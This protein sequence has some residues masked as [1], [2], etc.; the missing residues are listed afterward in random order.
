MPAIISYPSMLPQGQTRDQIVTIMDWFPTVLD[1]CGAKQE[2]SA[3]K[4]DGRSMTGVIA[5]PKA[6]SA[7][8]VLHF[9]WAKNW[10]VRR[11]DWKLIGAFEG[12][13][14]TMRLSLHNLAEPK[15]E[16]K[17]H[18]NEQPEI[19]RELTALH[20]AWEKDLAPK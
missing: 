3:P 18:A 8:D 9:G 4:L 20:E 19:V 12:K 2:A 14:G 13:T 10:A 17:D 11:G 1:L 15:P 16:V 6:A 7:H 5:G